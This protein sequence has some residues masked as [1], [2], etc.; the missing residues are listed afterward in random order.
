MEVLRR[1]S[2]H[3]DQGELLDAVHNSVPTEPFEAR[4]PTKKQVHRRL[5]DDQVDDLVAGYKRG[6]TVY[7]LADEFRI[8]R[9]TVSLILRR[10]G[11]AIRHR[12]LG[13]EQVV[14]ASEL[15]ANGL[16]LARVAET[17]GV[18]R[19]AVS[20]ALKAAGVE[21]RPRPGWPNPRKNFRRTL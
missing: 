6:N 21:L 13:P 11:V 7:Q 18:T 19:G 12:S 8:N 17:M 1:Y 16:S 14:Q 15:Y 2:N 3:L 9:E 5:R 4:T 10:Q 20:K